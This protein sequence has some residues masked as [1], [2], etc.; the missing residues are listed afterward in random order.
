MEE[1]GKKREEEEGKEERMLYNDK[2]WK[3]ISTYPPSYLLY[4]KT[5]SNQRP[6]FNA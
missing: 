6:K 3:N 4:I 2:F 1:E 5:P